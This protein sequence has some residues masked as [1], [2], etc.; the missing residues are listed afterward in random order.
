MLKALIE[1]RNKLVSELK[2]ITD[3]AV[4]ETRALTEDETKRF[5]SIKDEIE[6]IDASITRMK[7][8]ISSGLEPEDD[9]DNKGEGGSSN[10]GGA[11]ETRDM[12]DLDPAEVR[13]FAAF[14]RNDALQTR[15][16]EANL[17]MTDNGAIIPKTIA[18]QIIKQVKDNA[19]IFAAATK[20]NVRGNL[21]IPYYDEGTDHITVAWSNE[22]TELESHTGK[23]KTIDLT[24]YL[25]G[26]LT[27]ISRSLLN[28]QDFDLVTFIVNDMSEKIADFIEA[29][30]IGGTRVNGLAGVTSIVTAASATAITADEVI[31]LKDAVKDRFQNSCMFVMSSA[32][33]TAL[34]LLKD[35]DGRYLLQDDITAPFG[36][37]LLGKP[38]YV[39]DNMPEMASEK[40]AIYYGDF[41]GL[42]VKMVEEPNIQVLYEHFATQHAVGVV[43]WLEFDA[44][45][46]DAQKLA[47][48]K[49]AQAGA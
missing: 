31:K 21:S 34:R 33:R 3:A 45:V 49:M 36:S 22:F 7:E 37:T 30:I 32:T 38:V 44:K 2:G 8:A 39:S 10:K 46:Q 18:N 5:D 11:D 40:V 43:G 17:T 1:K 26:A 13:A 29:E 48:L 16:G 25:A 19:P 14:V 28:S 47:A 12:G 24:G 41:S 4:T 20:Y 15:D 35:G 23:F 42:A 6:K 9:D 27:K